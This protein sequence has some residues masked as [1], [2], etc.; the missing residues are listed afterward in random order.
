M[1]NIL[2]YLLITLSRIIW[3]ILHSPPKWFWIGLFIV[4][5]TFFFMMGRTYNH[6]DSGLTWEDTV[7][8]TNT[9]THEEYSRYLKCEYIYDVSR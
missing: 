8:C 2:K 6:E 7:D 9:I 4:Y 5:V 1:T 3:I